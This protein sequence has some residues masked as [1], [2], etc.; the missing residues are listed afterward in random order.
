MEL[1]E[2]ISQVN[3]VAGNSRLS[4]KSI[5]WNRL[6]SNRSSFKVEEFNSFL[7]PESGGAEGI[8]L[9]LL[10]PL[11]YEKRHKVWVERYKQFISCH[12]INTCPEP[13]IGEPKILQ[14]EGYECSVPYIKNFALAKLV[15]KQIEELK[16]S[17]PIKVLEV[18]AGYGGMAQVLLRKGVCSQYTIVDLPEMLPWSLSYLSQVFPE[19][20]C[21]VGAQGELSFYTPNLLTSISEKFDLIVNISSLGEMPKDVAIEYTSLLPGLLEDGG[22]LFSHN[23]QSRVGGGVK[24]HSD[25]GFH[26]KNIV[27][28]QSQPNIAGAFHDQHLLISVKNQAPTYITGDHLNFLSMLTALGLHEEVNALSNTLLRAQDDFV[29]TLSDSCRTYQKSI[30]RVS[31]YRALEVIASTDSVEDYQSVCIYLL[32]ILYFIEGDVLANDYAKIYLAEGRSRLAKAFCKKIL[33]L[34]YADNYLEEE[35]I[36]VSH[37]WLR[38]RLKRYLGLL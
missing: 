30:L 8:G 34:D 35:V 10:R 15:I 31:R 23:G 24:K 19:K 27:S 9:G 21:R 29:Q 6:I 13:A 25:Y 22:V 1:T 37:R 3:K 14:Y 17:S 18:G 38:K 36:A 33:S 2:A 5:F 20:T 11:D 28:I 7:N 26:N 16:F 4:K 32:A 12:E